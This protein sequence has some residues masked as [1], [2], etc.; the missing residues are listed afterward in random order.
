VSLI[1]GSA[2]TA[3]YI[4]DLSLASS[5][6]TLTVFAPDFS[7]S[8]AA[9]TVSGST[10]TAVIPAALVGSYL[11][12][13]SVTG[14]QVDARQDQ[15][16][17]VAASLDLVD[18]AD[19]RDELNISPSDTT[20][21]AKLRRWAKSATMVVEKI[22]GPILPRTRVDL[23]D[24]GLSFVVLPYRWVQSI[25][26]VVETRGVTNY[27]LTNQPLGA[28]VN[29]FGYTWNPNTNKIIRRA[30]GAESIFPL[31]PS[32]VAVT[33]TLGMASIPDDI[34][35]GAAELIKHW[36][37]KSEV[38]FRGAFSAAPQEEAGLM[39]GNYFIPNGVMELLEPWR[40]FPGFF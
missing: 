10:A 14:A 40:A 19:I 18:L 16:T 17:V 38:P 23:F 20:R 36:Y 29:A 35:Q 6:V 11:L 22:T 2:Y 12:V 31:G 13:W 15:F 21:N 8:T 3:F 4:A 24:G 34:Q 30:M 5:T 27:T 32:I 7:S 37:R 26:S 1:L 25:T 28:S 39:V 9:V 33:Y